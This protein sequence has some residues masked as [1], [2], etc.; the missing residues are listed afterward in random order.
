[1]RNGEA[2]VPPDAVVEACRSLARRG[3][4]SPDPAA[5]AE[6]QRQRAAYLLRRYQEGA[7]VVVARVTQEVERLSQHQGAA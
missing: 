1:M 3:S 5:A 6:E 4:F 2:V 7:K